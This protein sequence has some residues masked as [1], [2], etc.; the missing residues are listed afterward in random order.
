MMNLSE[1]QIALI[2][3]GV[4]ILLG[5]LV[6]N[7][8]KSR[9]KTINSDFSN[10]RSTASSPQFQEPKFKFNDDV[11]SNQ[12]KSEPEFNLPTNAS[13]PS[14]EIGLPSTA[15]SLSPR[16]DPAIDSVVFL[17]FAVPISG[18]E[19]LTQLLAWPKNT[20]YRYLIE[21]L[22]NKTSDLESSE[23][24]EWASIHPEF[25]YRELQLAVQLANRRGPIGVVD[26]SEFLSR[27]QS[28]ADLLDAEIDLPPAHD[29]VEQAKLI[30]QFCMTADIQLG[31]QLMANMISW[32]AKDVS[33]ALQNRGLILSRDGTYFHCYQ[34]DQLVFRVQAEEVNFL[35]DDLQ[36]RRIKQVQF[37]L[38]VPLAPSQFNP[39]IAMLE[40]ANELAVDLDGRLLDDNG[41]ALSSAAIDMI[42]NHLDSIYDM[43]KSRDVIPG[44]M[45]AQRLFS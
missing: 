41:Q 12:V 22:G 34:N 45:S 40:K 14:S 13:E 25:F 7:L 24:L 39:F 30:D 27:S 38:D 4:I 2:A 17:R 42:K 19:I 16:I 6:L 37:L 11:A 43:M 1:L 23:P 29:V 9:K 3:I 10:P 44:S 28:L 5:V 31:F 21:G 15:I 8:F 18:S 32:D 36:N 33:N 20:P 26:L 35:R